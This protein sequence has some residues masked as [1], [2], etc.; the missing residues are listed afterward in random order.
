MG[1]NLQVY[2]MPDMSTADLRKHWDSMVARARVEDGTDSYSGS[3][4]TTDGLTVR[5]YEPVIMSR[6]EAED[7]AEDET[8]KWG[9]A[10]ATKYKENEAERWLVA[11]L[12]AE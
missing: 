8:R 7:V 3:I 11:A 10:V 5:V 1:A 6:S 9:P 4:A 12:C 2:T